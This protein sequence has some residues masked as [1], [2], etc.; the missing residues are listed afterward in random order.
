MA[1]DDVF[2]RVP[3]SDPRVSPVANALAEAFPYLNSQV[4]FQVVAQVALDALD[5]FEQKDS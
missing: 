2:D 1:F 5:R 3:P 4:Y